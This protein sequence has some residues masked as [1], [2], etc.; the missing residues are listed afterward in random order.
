MTL[1]GFTEVVVSVENV[2][3]LRD[4]LSTVAGWTIKELPDA[5]VEQ[6]AAWRVPKSCTRIEQFLLTAE[7]DSNGHL[8]VVKF[9]G[10]EQQAKLMRSS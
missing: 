9:H 8:R 5:P 2:R 3:R 1:Q 6:L 7:N 4:T 10:C